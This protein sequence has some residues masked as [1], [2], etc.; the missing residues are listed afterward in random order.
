MSD[1]LRTGR[2]TSI[3]GGPEAAIPA[4]EYLSSKDIEERIAKLGDIRRD[5]AAA[6]LAVEALQ[7]DAGIKKQE[8]DKLKKLLIDLDAD[9][10]TAEAV[11][12]VPEDSLARLIDRANKKGCLRGIFDGVA[13]GFL[14]G[15]LSS[16]CVW[17]FT[18]P[19]S[20]P[21]APASVSTPGNPPPA[22]PTKP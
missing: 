5:L 18:Q 11:L 14:T 10:R 4:N 20:P 17:Y 2:V 15:V 3:P 12:R 7:F 21:V 13:I 1:Q 22:M 8:H 16:L 6:V 9:R 19:Q